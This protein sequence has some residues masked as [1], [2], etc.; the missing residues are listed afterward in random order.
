MGKNEKALGTQDVK[1]V[2]SPT[3]VLNT[4]DCKCLHFIARIPG[5]DKGFNKDKCDQSILQAPFLYEVPE[6]S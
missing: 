1:N 4:L 2:S 3:P 5:P 6:G